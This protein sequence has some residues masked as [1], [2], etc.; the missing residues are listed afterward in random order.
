MVRIEISWVAIGDY[1]GEALEVK[2]RS[3]TDA[4][5]SWAEA[6]RHKGN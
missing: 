2:G 3:E 1:M 4:A 5:R 6:A